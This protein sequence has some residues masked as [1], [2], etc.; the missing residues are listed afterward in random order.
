[1]DP[2]TGL[3]HVQPAGKT[4]RQTGVKQH[5][6][7]PAIGYNGYCLQVFTRSRTTDLP[8]VAE[9]QNPGRKC[10]VTAFVYELA[11]TW[12]VT[13]YCV[14]L[15]GINNNTA[16]LAAERTKVLTCS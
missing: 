4:D 7:W 12:L 5:H 11:N 6:N 8:N 13:I 3:K 2:H 1:M 16:V 10:C 9:K 15:C 14:F